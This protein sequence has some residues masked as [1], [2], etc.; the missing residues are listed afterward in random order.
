MLRSNAP[1][2]RTRG[3]QTVVDGRSIPY[4]RSGRIFGMPEGTQGDIRFIGEALF[5]A[6]GWNS[7]Q[8]YT[9]TVP[10]A[11]TID[12]IAVVCVG[13][14]GAGECSHDGSSA[15][16]GA[17][18]YKNDIPVTPGTQ[19]E[20][21]VGGGGRNPNATHNSNKYDGNPSYIR[22]AGQNYAV[23]GGGEGGWAHPSP[24]WGNINGGTRNPSNSDGGGNGGAGTDA[25]GTRTGGGGAGGYSGNGG[26]SGPAGSYPIS[27]APGSPPASNGLGGGGSGGN[28]YNSS[29]GAGGGGGT[30]VYGEG[31]GGV[32]GPN[33]PTSTWYNNYGRGGS[34]A[35]N[36]GLNGYVTYP[37]S[38]NNIPGINRPTGYWGDGPSPNPTVYVNYR[39]DYPGPGYPQYVGDGGFCGGGGCGGHSSSYPGAGGH[40]M[41]RIVYG[42]NG[43]AI[44]ANKREF[45][46]TFV[47]RSDQYVNNVN[48]AKVTI[49]D[50]NG[51]QLM[52]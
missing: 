51:E 26:N 38:I 3:Q 5:H 45:P 22:I 44:P 52:Y 25:S 41:V 15:G 21:Y 19:V 14:G 39:S 32:A 13:G 47:D 10:D 40:G 35:Y 24:T 1:G 8:P 20:V 2:T 18:A 12:Y 30:G 6:S 31:A 50:V 43:P 48:P 28:S 33:Q 9:W 49:D 16:G 37:G 27:G 36:T 11:S 46:T 17:L 7:Q 4:T 34:T 42:Y 29:D 23:A